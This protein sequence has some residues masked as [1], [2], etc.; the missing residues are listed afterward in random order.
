MAAYPPL[1]TDVNKRPVPQVWDP[2]A[3]VW[4]VLAGFEHGQQGRLL[5]KNGNPIDENNPLEVKVRE[6]EKLLGAMVENPEAWTVGD[7]IK[8][9]ETLLR[10]GEG[11]ISIAGQS[12]GLTE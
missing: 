12:G 8:R 3:G 1:I 11:K 5:D 10:S 4:R 6:L 9:V 7:R 2:V